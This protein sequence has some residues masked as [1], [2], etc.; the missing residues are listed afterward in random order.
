M[1][2]MPMPTPIPIS[3]WSRKPNAFPPPILTHSHT[4]ALFC[5]P[6][7]RLL[8]PSPGVYNSAM[9]TPPWTKTLRSRLGGSWY[10]A[11]PTKLRAEIDGYLEAAAPEQALENACA[12]LLPHAGYL[13]SGAV[14][15][16]GVAAV[17][18]R[19]FDRVVVLGPS[20]RVPMPNLVSAPR[21][22]AFETVLGTIPLDQDVIA[23]LLESPFF[24]AVPAAE[25]GEHSVEIE[26]PLLQAALTPGFRLV[27]LTVGQLDERAIRGAAAALAKELDPHTLL[28][29]SSDFTHYGA[30]FGYVPFLDDLE[31]NLRRLDLGAFEEIQKKDL[32]GFRRYVQDTGATICG[33]DAIS[34][35]LALLPKD[36]AV[37]LLKYDT[38]GRMTGDWRHTV[39]YVSAA[40]TGTWEQERHAI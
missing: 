23:R 1:P 10:A 11:D 28:V 37:H 27:P 35:L 17:K 3:I 25:S 16:F 33:R 29:V 8:A 15:A 34:L 4:H 22:A 36:A 9:K 31:A 20:H 5:L 26:L 24:Q 40:V 39:S 13:Y 32:K 12:L 7:F 21:A 30:D 19:A 18:G 6:V 2:V 14:A 38:S